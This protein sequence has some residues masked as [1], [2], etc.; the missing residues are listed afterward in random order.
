MFSWLRCGEGFGFVIYGEFPVRELGG[1]G[2]IIMV[3]EQGRS[4]LVRLLSTTTSKP[5]KDE[6][7]D[8]QET[9]HPSYDT[10]YRENSSE[11]SVNG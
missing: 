5:E 4:F 7:G 8:D 6:E 11:R 9:S 3:D 10:A 1:W 2:F